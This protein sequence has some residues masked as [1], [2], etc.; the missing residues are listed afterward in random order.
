MQLNYCLC[1]QEARNYLPLHLIAG[2]NTGRS[3]Q[4]FKMVVHPLDPTV[5]IQGLQ[6][7]QSVWSIHTV[8]IYL[9][10]LNC[11]SAVRS[12]ETFGR[13]GKESEVIGRH[14]V[15]WHCSFREQGLCRDA[16]VSEFSTSVEKKEGGSWSL[17][18]VFSSPSSEEEGGD[19]PT[20]SRFSPDCWEPVAMSMFSLSAAVVKRIKEVFMC[21][22]KW[23]ILQ[24]WP[25]AKW[26]V[27]E[28]EM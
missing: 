3:T 15:P 12:Y 14:K 10:W 21:V 26:Y 7:Y 5:G 9:C 23:M 13:V 8:K 22:T 11:P 17:L 25:D 16:F 24:A 20:T 2:S 18:Q 28:Q 19:R 4:C 6:L 1:V 27:K